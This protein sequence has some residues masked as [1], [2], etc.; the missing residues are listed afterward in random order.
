[1]GTRRDYSQLLSEESGAGLTSRGGLQT[2]RFML[3]IQI[4]C[5]RKESLGNPDG[6]QLFK[7]TSWLWAS[8]WN[9]L[10]LQTN[11]HPDSLSR[12][13]LS[14]HLSNLLNKMQ[15]SS[16]LQSVIAEMSCFTVRGLSHCM[17]MKTKKKVREGLGWQH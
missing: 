12:V 11:T 13:I 14:C 2:K 8:F 16:N 10:W 17:E 6:L 5:Y 1:M 3:F 9:K 7:V 15:M 4:A